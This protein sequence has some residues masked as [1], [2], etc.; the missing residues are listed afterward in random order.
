MEKKEFYIIQ[1]NEFDQ[2]VLDKLGFE[3][4]CVAENEWNNDSS[5]T[6]NN[7]TKNGILNDSVFMKYD[8]PKV[9]ESIN[10]KKIHRN[11]WAIGLLN[12]MVIK[13]MIPEGNYII[14]VCW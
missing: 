9:E 6:F 1:D 12:Y 8:L 3:Y 5:Y 14:E 11:V 10:D 7:L 2:L 4:E 13:D